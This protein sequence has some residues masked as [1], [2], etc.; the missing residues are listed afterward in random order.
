MSR[1]VTL[2]LASGVGIICAAFALTAI[3]NSFAAED[4]TATKGYLLEEEPKDAQDVKAVRKLGKHG[5]E[6]VIV[7]RIGGRKVPWVKGAAAFTMVD[8]SLQSC[9]QIHGDSCPTPWD[10]C[11][12]ADLA[13]ATVLVAFL[14]EAG[15]IVKQDARE[16]LKIKELQT[17]V[18]LGKIKRDAAGNVTILASRIF[19][20]EDELE[21]R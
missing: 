11:C 18:I 21:T 7:G 14:D 13:Q 16:M 10:Y 8:A 3:T 6:V 20:R 2:C 9:D 19:V 4:S 17:V 15:K 5:E 12:E 1:P